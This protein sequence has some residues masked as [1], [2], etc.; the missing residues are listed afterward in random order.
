MVKK[1]VLGALAAF[2]LAGSQIS[3]NDETMYANYSPALQY[4]ENPIESIA[5]QE[6]ESVPELSENDRLLAQC[7]DGEYDFD[8]RCIDFTQGY[9]DNI[10][11]SIYRIERIARY[12]QDGKQ[13]EEK[14]YCSSTLIEDGIVITAKH[15]A[16]FRSLDARGIK[17]DMEINL[18]REG[19]RYGLETIL[20]G[21]K[22]FAILMMKKPANIPFFPYELGDTTGLQAGNFTY[23]I[24]YVDKSYPMIRDG[25]VTRME[26]NDAGWNEGYFLVSN[27]IHFG[28]SGGAT[29][30]F[31]DGIPEF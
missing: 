29:I 17:Y 1:A 18:M 7:H 11:N 4:E 3:A 26:P 24:G 12:E 27:G 20:K 21:N 22:D 31:R 16:H 6:T 23:M 10:V 14:S 25:I 2:S 15:C 30:A 9:V 13:E 19:R 28:D 8:T 5:P